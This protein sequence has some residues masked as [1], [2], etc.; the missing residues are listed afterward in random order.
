MKLVIGIDGGGTHTRVLVADLAGRVVACA[1]GGGAS[2][3]HEPRARKNVRQTI[4]E[5]LSLAGAHP[6]DVI[7]LTAG[8]AG[9]DRPAD[10]KWVS[11]LT[12]VP[13]LRCA[14]AHVNDAVVAHRGAFGGGSGIIVIAGTG[15]ITFAINELGRQVR[16]F[17][18]HHYAWSG[19]P[20][21]GRE[22]VYEI[23]AG[24]ADS[25]DAALTERVM[26]HLGATTTGEL[27]ELGAGGFKPDRHERNRLFGQMA[28]I[29]TDS[30]LQGS[31]L[32]QA[33]CDRAIHQVIVGVR[34]I[35]GMFGRRPI[36]VALIGGVANSGYFK[37]CITARL[38]AD[39]N[40]RVMT[41]Q[42]SAAAGA[43]LMALASAGVTVNDAILSKLRQHPQAVQ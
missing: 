29:V 23:L 41:P 31:S 13:G 11:A 15:S 18:F 1:A 2:V 32:A 20:A 19:A 7:G 42:F 4:G 17:D 9:Y 33:I 38:H 36:P 24:H 28:P 22:A 5:A 10:L 43:V 26:R 40:Y 25:S 27:R 16:N 3:K 34:M 35:G 6:Q 39:D 21:L 12:N 30:A 14:R 37:Q 8:I